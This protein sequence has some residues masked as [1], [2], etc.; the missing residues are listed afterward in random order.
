MPLA[1]CGI[2][3]HP[4]AKARS[5]STQVRVD[6]GLHNQ[7]RC[8]HTGSHTWKSGIAAQAAAGQAR[9]GRIF[10]RI[11][12]PL[13]SMSWQVPF[14]GQST[15]L[16]CAREPSHIWAAGFAGRSVRLCSFW[17][18]WP[19]QAG[20]SGFGLSHAVTS[21]VTAVCDELTATCHIYLSQALSH[22][23]V[24][25]SVSGR[26]TACGESN[27]PKPVGWGKQRPVAS[28]A[29]RGLRAGVPSWACPSLAAGTGSRSSRAPWFMEANPRSP[30]KWDPRST[31]MP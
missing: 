14:L 21:S 31:R 1:L 20:A 29:V 11:E 24:T 4:Y 22:L 13:A 17:P 23:S 28:P 9:T 10:N 26:T 3:C 8:L 15:A 30:A 2:E 5:E 16:H 6:T 25:G 27:N 7:R 18:C 12:V 19:S